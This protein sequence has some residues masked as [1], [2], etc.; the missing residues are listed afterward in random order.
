MSAR[1]GD[2]GQ[3]RARSAVLPREGLLEP[4]VSEDPLG[5]LGRPP[6]SVLPRCLHALSRRCVV[7]GGQQAV[8][9]RGQPRRGELQD[10]G[11]RESRPAHRHQ[12]PQGPAVSELDADDLAVGLAVSGRHLPELQGPVGH[13]VNTAPVRSRLPFGA[14]VRELIRWTRAAAL[15]AYERQELP[16][17]LLVKE[18]AP[19]GPRGRSPLVSVLFT[20]SSGRR[21]TCACPASALPDRPRP[22]A[23]HPLPE[24]LRPLSLARLD[25]R[26]HPLSSTQRPASGV[27]GPRG[28]DIP[29]LQVMLNRPVA[30]AAVARI[31]SPA[32]AATRGHRPFVLGT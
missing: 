15:D 20:S 22:R 29:S 6:A 30:T 25:D 27:I 12:S 19:P 32:R 2:A 10:V 18:L 1:P 23:R 21:R 3:D 28:P 9:C 8:G 11:E 7:L 31:S 14:A 26:P 4:R 13:F 16:F 5:G 24:H 17:E